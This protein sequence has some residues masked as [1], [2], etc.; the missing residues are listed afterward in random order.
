MSVENFQES[1]KLDT[2]IEESHG[3]NTFIESGFGTMSTCVSKM[4]QEKDDGAESVVS[5]LTNASRVQLPPQEEKEVISA[6]ARD[7]CQ[8]I[9]ITGDLEA[10]RRIATRLPDLLR[11]YTMRLEPRVKSKIESDAIE[12]IRQQR[13]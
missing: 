6:F 13:K 1:R 11:A 3:N 2:A 5:I 7:L 9:A 12:F 4:N 8:D 10:R